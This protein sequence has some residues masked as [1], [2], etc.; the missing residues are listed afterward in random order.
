MADVAC[1]LSV[2]TELD[3]P[4]LMR[5]KEKVFRFPKGT[6]SDTYVPGERFRPKQ[7]C[8]FNEVGGN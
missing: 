5:L 7:A 1:H 8:A 4:I 2:F 6:Q 3:V